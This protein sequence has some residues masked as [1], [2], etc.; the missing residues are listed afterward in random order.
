[1]CVNE[2]QNPANNL[3]T[4]GADYAWTD[5]TYLLHKANVSWAYYLSEGAEPDCEN[6]GDMTCTPKQQPAKVPG[7]WNAL[8]GFD[9]VKQDVKPG[10]IQPTAKYFTAAKAGTLP[11]V[12]WIVPTGRISEHPPG[13]VSDG[14]AYVTGVIN[15]AMQGP[16][17]SS[18]AIFL[19]WDDWG[20]FY[21]H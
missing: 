17:W 14:Q 16:E 19:S 7:I 13:L 12:S 21:D 5:V 20:G 3:Q 2:L 8:P 18:T 9:T 4:L 11:A 10:N 15:A 1:S 6:D